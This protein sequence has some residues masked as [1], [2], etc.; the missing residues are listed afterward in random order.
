M[1][2]DERCFVN[3]VFQVLRWS[4]SLTDNSDHEYNS[5]DGDNQCKNLVLL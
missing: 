5:K 2:V 4:M 1:G 3:V